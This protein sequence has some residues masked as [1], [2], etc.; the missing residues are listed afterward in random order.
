MAKNLVDL[1]LGAKFKFGSIYDEPIIWKVSDKHHDG[2]PENSV[3][4]VTEN[5]IKA[6]CFDAKEPSNSQQNRQS[7]GNERYAYS[8]IRQWLNSD[9]SAGQWYTPQ[10]GADAPPNASNVSENN[11]QPINPYEAQE[12]FLCG[13]TSEE[14]KL[15]LPTTITVKKIVLMGVVQKVVQIKSF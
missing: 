8:N 12:G 14:K 15:L 10:H 1:P 6:L 7:S 2:Y 11:G 3:T 13:F 9:A 4:L 5:M